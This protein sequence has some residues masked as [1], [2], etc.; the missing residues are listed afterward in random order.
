LKN[1]DPGST[2]P[3]GPSAGARAAGRIA[4]ND[5]LL[6]ARSAISASCSSIW[7]D[8]KRLT[9]ISNIRRHSRYDHKIQ[10]T[11]SGCIVSRRAAT[12]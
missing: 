1:S 5:D 12:I 10:H 9:D 3:T 4:S 2:A 8:R 6:T 7:P 11:D